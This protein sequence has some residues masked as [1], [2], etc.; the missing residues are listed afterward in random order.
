[1]SSHQISPSLP[2]DH[3][4]RAAVLDTHRSF[5]VSAPAG[6]GKT[7]LLTQRV[8]ALLSQCDQPEN[9][10]A[11][12]FT[13]KAAAEMQHRIITALH[14]TQQK[15]NL[16]E[17]PPTDD[18]ARTTWD[19]ATQVL[20]RNDEKQ[21][22]LLSLPNRLNITTIDS[23]CRQLSQQTPLT[24]DLGGIPDVLD[25]A[26]INYVY[27]LAARD[28]LASLESDQRIKPDLIRLIKHFNNQL[29]TLEELFMRLL[30]RRDQWLSLLYATKNQREYLEETLQAVISDHLQKTTEAML[31]Y[32]GEILELADF[33]A[34]NCLH[35]NI[36]SAVNA[37]IGITEMP[38]VH[39]DAIKQWLGLTELIT[40]K[41]GDLRKSVTK[42]IGFPA[43]DKNN[44]SDEDNLINKRQKQ[45]INEL[46]KELKADTHLAELL[47]QIR[48]LPSPYYNDSQWDLLDS[49]TRV[50]LVLVAKLNLTFINLGK[51]DF[52]NITLAALSA[53]G[54]EEEPT[55]LALILDYRIQH[56]LVDEFQ[57][58][59]TPQLHLLKKLTAGWQPD[60]GRSLFLV[61]D[62]MQS[63]YSFR[64]ANVGIFLNVRQHGLGDIALEAV[65][66]TVNFRSDNAIV[67]WC[68]Q[69]FSHVFPVD[70]ETNQGAVKYQKALAFNTDDADLTLGSSNK[71]VASYIFIS[72]E[73]S[74][75]RL[76]EA[77][78]IVELI[79]SAQKNNARQSI[80][81]LVRKR[82]QVNAISQVLDAQKIT[83]RATD[84]NRLD[85]D[86][87]IIDL[88]SL[89]RALLY[90]NDKLAWFSLLRAPWCG[91]DM[92]DLYY[93]G[94]YNIQHQHAT[95]IASL[96]DLV[97]TQTT[98][99]TK[100]YA[101]DTTR[102]SLSVAG[103]CILD[104]F[105]KIIEQI[106]ASQGRCDLRGWV[107]SAWLQLGGGALLK[108]LTEYPKITNYFSLLE[109]YQQGCSLAHWPTFDA[110]INT[111]Y[112]KS[113]IDTN[114]SSP[115]VEIMTIHK[116]K[117]LEFDTVIIPGLDSA[118][119]SDKQELIAWQEWLDEHQQPRLLISPVHATGNSKDR[120]DT[121][122]DYIR[123][124]HKRRQALESDR[125]FYVG[126]TRAIHHLY[127]LANYTSPNDTAQNRVGQIE[128]IDAGIKPSTLLGS[129]W[130]DIKEC[131]QI[132]N[133]DHVDETSLA[134]A[135]QQN[136]T[137]QN[138]LS[139]PGIIAR[140]SSS[141]HDC[142][143]SESNLLADYRL[144][145]H[146]QSLETDNRVKPD[147][148]LQRHARYFGNV[149]HRALQ[150]VTETDYR[151][152]QPQRI[153]EQ[154]LFWQ[155]G[156]EQMGTPVSLAVQQSHQLTHIIAQV[157][158][159]DVGRWILDHQH[160]NSAC[161]LRLLR[162]A[163]N[164][165]V[166]EYIIDRTFVDRDTNV[167]WIIDYKS[168][169]PSVDQTLENFLT[170]QSDLYKVQLDTYRQLFDTQV[171]AISCALYFPLIDSFHIVFT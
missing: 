78:K 157:L 161:E 143:Y 65:N 165:E 19:L 155:L 2:Q 12:T 61:G 23:F 125:L 85:T 17:A 49:L 93:V 152:W 114:A 6:S 120:R 46:L 60:D 44:R 111:L 166:K 122:H 164:N 104:R 132:I 150:A 169:Q 162:M 140:L 53:L 133:T 171:N 156:L 97:A 38:S 96:N 26:E 82:S 73:K 103:L 29:G 1:M 117:G 154:R 167:R 87:S 76:H 4:I 67:N 30:Q 88:R 94:Q 116:S 145:H 130:P 48:T 121:V 27:Q 42:N 148:L 52:I 142:A 138:S 33:A 118:A 168:S 50:L 62:A 105:V 22:Q 83:Y 70:D 71:A 170:E 13:K 144:Q 115:P 92:H 108:E 81:I 139:S 45:R 149:L 7:G 124:Q 31:P 131:V 112:A 113:I 95:L 135:S 141:W 163:K 159:S 160:E 101:G 59:S 36:E 43:V 57:D 99:L 51:T 10:L 3:A 9:I 35:D 16:G 106:M 86:M 24:N 32:S 123:G 146:A 147:A 75:Q 54:D 58:T 74:K 15:I 158:T 100:E 126:C 151:Q 28:T 34:N 91:L 63:C 25:N 119:A 14:S 11:I 55:N 18:Y 68:N 98:T 5:A 64:D 21:W 153:D 128:A 39:H 37:C 102:I 40:I 69:V 134:L 110:A 109:K 72:A 137:E 20:K 84:I 56:I 41:S 80:A 129:I 8:L 77:N 47:H 66:L 89:T 107:E 127:L 136:R 90:P 79:S